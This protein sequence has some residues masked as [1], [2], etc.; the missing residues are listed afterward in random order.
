M[1]KW[2][3]NFRLWHWIHALVVLG[4]I[5]TVILR[6]TFLSWR[7]NSEILI[8]K[9]F[10]MDLDITQEQAKIL[11]KAV[12]SGM[13]D[14]HYFLGYGLA[15]LLVYR[16]ILFFT[17]SG[18]YNYKNFKALSIH[19]KMVSIGYIGIYAILT[20]L[21]LSGLAMHFY[22]DLGLEKS[23]FKDLKDIHEF[24]YTAVWAF[25]ALHLAG[26]FIAENTDEKGIVSDMLN[27]GK[28]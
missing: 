10:D 18:K 3:L 21:A 26:I 22:K 2:S 28:K 7:T 20:F 14:W 13:W 27:G 24:V 5:T 11:A 16:L 19:K 4:L 15:F 17:D 9:L 25:V 8:D 6:K 12:R 23:T 1:K